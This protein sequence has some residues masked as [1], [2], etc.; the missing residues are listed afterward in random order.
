[1][2]GAENQ[3]NKKKLFCVLEILKKYSDDQHPITAN[4]IAEKLKSI[5]NIEAERK[6]IYRDINVLK[7]CDYNIMKISA[8]GF[9]LADRTFE[10]P[11]IRL[12][13][14]A[15]LGARF[16]TAKKTKE[17]SKKLQN[18]LSVYQ[19]KRIESQTYF[20]NRVKF[21]NEHILY[22]IDTIHTAIAENKKVRFEYYRRQIVDNE[23]KR[24]FS[25]EHLISPYALV[26][27]EDKYYLLGN[28]EKY[29]NISHYRLDRM[30][31][32]VVTNLPSRS[33]EEVSCYKNNFDTGDYVTKTFQMYSGTD[34]MIDLICNN[35]ILEKIVDK[36]GERVHYMCCGAEKFRV[37][38]RGYNSDGL[39]EWL[40]M[41]G[42]KCFVA[43]PDSLR[44]AVIKRSKDIINMQNS[45]DQSDE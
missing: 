9:C 14:D 27:S 23:I 38:V 28:Y 5:Y 4:D 17:L 25:R 31:R 10:I 16:I 13:N 18:E 19:A 41:I 30:D 1:M 42:D 11:E 26:W 22:V 32:V 40:L 37:R 6:S 2:A 44:E 45:I 12:L 21:T 15:I 36:F 7:E 20:D 3:S 29:D 39:V 8:N 35:D 24:V 33:F 43:S 34:E